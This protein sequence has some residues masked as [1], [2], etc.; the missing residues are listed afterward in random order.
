VPAPSDNF[1]AMPDYIRN[2]AEHNRT[3]S[4]FSKI[5]LVSHASSVLFDDGEVNCSPYLSR[6]YKQTIAWKWT[7]SLKILQYQYPYLDPYAKQLKHSLHSCAH[8]ILQNRKIGKKSWWIVVI[9]Q[10]RQSFFPSKVFYYMV[11]SLKESTMDDHV[12]IYIYH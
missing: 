6:I 4:V 1:L 8:L 3:N 5:Y 2:I 7:S 9:R 11:Y 10:I 12:Y